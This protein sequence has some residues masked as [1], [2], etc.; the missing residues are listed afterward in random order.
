[1]ASFR[2]IASGKWQAQVCRK[3]VRKSQCFEYLERAQQWAEKVEAT[4]K[5]DAI[6]LPES[7]I[8][9]DGKEL[10]EIYVRAK[11]HARERGI[12]FEINR[13]DIVMIYGRSNGKCQVSSITFNR[14]RPAGS[15]KRP[16]FPSLD[17]IDSAAAYTPKNCR[18]VCVAVNFAMGEWGEWVVRALASAISFGRPGSLRNGAEA[19]PYQFPELDGTP[20]YRQ[21]A[22]RKA[23]QK[24]PFMTH[25]SE[26]Q[27]KAH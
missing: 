5:A 19:L 24:N 2:Q 22:R 14:F 27:I 4:I 17:R 1:M 3:G 6:G 7:G 20:T 10:T 13:D 18:L 12:P 15:T 9:L 23:R 11:D 26:I 8:R 16:W 25:G 21:Q